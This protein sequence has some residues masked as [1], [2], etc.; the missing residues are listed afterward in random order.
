MTNQEED[1]PMGVTEKKLKL[2][3]EN[4]KRVATANTKK[5]NQGLTVITK[6]DPF[7]E[8]ADWNKPIQ[9]YDKSQ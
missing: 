2:N 6:D 4:I 7:R 9:S 8:E 5:N 3:L 1:N